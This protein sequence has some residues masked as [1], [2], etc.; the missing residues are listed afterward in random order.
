[1]GFFSGYAIIRLVAPASVTLT[2]G[3][4]T[5]TFGVAR[6]NMFPD[7]VHYSRNDSP[8]WK[9]RDWETANKLL[10]YLEPNRRPFAIFTLPDN[11]YV[12]CLG[13]KT[14]LT[15]EARE[16]Q[17]DGSFTHWVFGRGAPVRAPE[18]IEVS[19]GTVTVDAS[20]I[21]ALRD[22]RL[23][24][25][26]FLETRTFPTAYDRQDITERFTSNHCA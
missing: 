20:Q 15:V 2:G 24:I 1:M 18:R 25:R 4:E 17:H 21:L 19:T 26:Q 9:I 16:Y 13:S 23:I 12:Q 3:I 6:T 8:G 7:P 10:S 5:L 22:A 11:S 14:R